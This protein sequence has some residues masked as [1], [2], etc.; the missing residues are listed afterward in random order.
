V[1]GGGF[2]PLFATPQSPAY[3]FED[4]PRFVTWHAT[5]I[6]RAYSG[7]S[8]AA[9]CVWRS[10]RPEITGHHA[11]SL[12]RRVLSHGEQ[13]PPHDAN[14]AWPRRNAVMG[15]EGAVDIVYKRELAK[16]AGNPSAPSSARKNRR[17]PRPLRQS[18]VREACYTTP[19]RAANTRAASHRPTRPRKQ[20]AT[21]TQEEHGH[22]PL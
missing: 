12:W 9:L 11:Q 17:I 22:I 3:N 14:F 20:A 7:R 15:T 10:D 19:H 13:A 5:R 18:L 2:R 16:V 21:P 6:R 8:E 1:K 4:V